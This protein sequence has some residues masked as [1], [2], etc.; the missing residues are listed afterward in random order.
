MESFP[1]SWVTPK[2]AP[3]P[4]SFPFSYESWTPPPPLNQLFVLDG[5]N[6]P[7]A[8]AVLGF[9]LA[10]A[11]VSTAGAM[12]SGGKDGYAHQGGYPPQGL[13][14]GGYPG[15]QGQQQGY[16]PPQGQQGQGQQRQGSY[17][18]GQQGQQGQWGQGQQGGYV[19]QDGSLG[20]AASPVIPDGARWA[21]SAPMGT[22]GNPVV[23]TTIGTPAVNPGNP[24]A[25]RREAA[26]SVDEL[27]DLMED[28]WEDPQ[29]GFQQDYPP[30]GGSPPDYLP[31]PSAPALVEAAKAAWRASQ[32]EPSSLA[33]GRDYPRYTG[34][35]GREEPSFRAQPQP[36]PPDGR[37]SVGAA[38]EGRTSRRRGE[39][40]YGGDVYGE[41]VYGQALARGPPPREPP[42]SA[43][44]VVEAAKATWRANQLGRSPRPPGDPSEA[45]RDPAALRAGPSSRRPPQPSAPP[46]QPRGQHAIRSHPS[47]SRCWFLHRAGRP[48]LRSQACGVACWRGTAARR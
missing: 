36:P 47:C 48:S 18:Q 15:Q 6:G 38:G 2:P 39:D 1:F 12:R 3:L 40:V 41:D 23:G 28:Y 30:R 22:P 8:A 14:Q 43:R 26:A 5:W 24:A 37:P 25:A 31:P 13:Q 11:A 7:T 20:S 45:F 19:P 4:A 46:Q 34:R 16:P 44:A 21:P 42:P 33:G 32:D 27:L 35:R 29:Q 17:Q 9:G 10:A